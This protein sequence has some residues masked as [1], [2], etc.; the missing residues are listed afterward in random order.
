M[1][2]KYISKKQVEDLMRR[3]YVNNESRSV[4]LDASMFRQV[5]LYLGLREDYYGT[6]CDIKEESEIN[7]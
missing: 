3:V 2:N 4:A 5:C 6:G 1:E 7:E